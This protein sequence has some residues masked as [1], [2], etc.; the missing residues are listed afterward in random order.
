MRAW[1]KLI[2]GMELVGTPYPNTEEE[3]QA[4]EK[5]HSLK[6]PEEYREYCKII[7]GGDFNEV[8]SVHCLA[9]TRPVEEQL[10]D[11]FDFRSVLK[12]AFKN[13]SSMQHIIDSSFIFAFGVEDHNLY[14]LLDLSSYDKKRKDCDIYVLHWLKQEY[15]NL[16]RSFYKFISDFCV[17]ETAKRE[18][19][20]LLCDD[21]FNYSNTLV[22]YS[23]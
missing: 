20:N 1:R 8:L 19:P 6:L 2:S 5:A 15:H 3:L 11:Q 16:G 4:F 14:F 23:A 10:E 12:S 21:D 9:H 13:N 17:S 7:G 22:Y 18:Y